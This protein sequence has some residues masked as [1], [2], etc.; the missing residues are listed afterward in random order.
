MPPCVV[1]HLRVRVV[2]GPLKT[3]FE[4]LR[5]PHNLPDLDK[6]HVFRPKLAEPMV[7]RNPMGRYRLTHSPGVSAGGEL[8]RFG[9]NMLEF[10]CSLLVNSSFMLIATGIP[11][12]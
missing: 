11:G 5:P 9:R 3:D 1:A 8:E 6:I 4:P 10:L 12:R 2:L 7:V